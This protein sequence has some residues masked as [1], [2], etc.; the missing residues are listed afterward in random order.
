MAGLAGK[1]YTM[2]QRLQ[3]FVEKS[4]GI[5]FFKG[6]E[7]TL[8]QRIDWGTVNEC[9]ILHSE[10]KQ[11]LARLGQ[12]LPAE[13]IRTWQNELKANQ[14]AAEAGLAPQPIF[15]DEDSL[16]AI[17]PW[18]GDPLS[19]VELTPELLKEIA[20]RLSLLHGIES[21]VA[22]V[23][24]RDTIENYLSIISKNANWLNK[25]A[26]DHLALLDQAD[27]WDKSE[28]LSF[29]HHDL[30][31]GNI[32]WDGKQCTFIDWEYARVA[33]PLFDL[34]SLSNHFAL[35]DKDLKLLLAQYQ[36]HEYLEKEVRD[37]E[38]MVHGLE[39]LWLEAARISLVNKEK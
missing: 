18:C 28:D 20:H 35:T 14:I 26:I 8:G 16:A 27:I 5:G 33:H 12:N 22:Q 7:I 34:A 17:Y 38:K 24:Y 6:K 2:T 19:Q 30:N 39:K 4:Q 13:F 36:H 32:L 23:G 11:Y 29:C 1:N 21:P 15:I 31:P 10:E 25:S 3:N 9:W 37:A